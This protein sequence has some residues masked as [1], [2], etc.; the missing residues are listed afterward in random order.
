MTRSRASL[1]WPFDELQ[2]LA[3]PF[4]LQFTTPEVAAWRQCINPCSVLSEYKT[5]SSA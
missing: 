4:W 2:F 3:L 1:K 5:V